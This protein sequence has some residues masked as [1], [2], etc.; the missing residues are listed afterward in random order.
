M[1][2][3]ALGVC[4]FKSKCKSRDIA[5]RPR[6]CL[7]ALAKSSNAILHIR[8]VEQKH[9]VMS[10]KLVVDKLWLCL[11]PSF[12]P[13]LL[14][15]ATTIAT[16]ARPITAYQPRRC[17][18]DKSNAKSR[19]HWQ[20]PGAKSKPRPWTNGA[21]A[22]DPDSLASLSVDQ[23]EGRLA[24]V[25]T[26]EPSVSRVRAILRCLIVDHGVKPK[27]EYYRALMLAHASASEGSVVGLTHVLEEIEEAGI[28]MD[29][30]L[31]HAALKVLKTATG[32]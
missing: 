1:E 11:C 26:A 4:P 10:Q 6:N 15:R 25:A 8:A 7:H 16:A 5:N 12:T 20:K 14:R 28:S 29:S 2:M 23:L 21:V 24:H 27:L 17:L 32:R 9:N 19:L 18:S 30:S 3:D 31:L 13:A 22:D